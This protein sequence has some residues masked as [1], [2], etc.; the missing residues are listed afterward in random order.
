MRLLPLL[1][2]TVG[3]LAGCESVP[4][5][6]GFL[7][8]APKP[9][10]EIRDV[11]FAD[12]SLDSVKLNFE[13]DVKNPY[14]VPLPLTNIRYALATGES[15]GADA[16]QKA[17]GTSLASGEV[18][19]P[20]TI[21]AGGTKGVTVP[22]ELRFADM[23]AAVKGLRPG[24]VI[25]YRANLD[26]SVQPPGVG[27]PL[28]LPLAHRGEVPIPAP[29]AVS[30]ETIEWEKLSLTQAKGLVKIRVEN[31]N[32]FSLDLGGFRYGLALNGKSLLSGAV[33]KPMNFG[34]GKE[35][36]L[37]VPVELN[38]FQAGT[39]LFRALQT[40]RADYGLDGSMTVKTPFGSFDHDYEKKGLVSMK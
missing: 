25:P 29:P 5:L 7:E 16:E 8:S 31:P 27:S 23:L 3:L 17:G 10:A 38:A 33:D 14:P 9:S 28:V 20:G 26:F 22:V 15:A 35:Q 30:L 13:V 37:A 24:K 11:A 18:T 40:G 2:L 32:D 36:E 4:A 19:D 6:K 34:A 39:A 12:L 1:L 21:P